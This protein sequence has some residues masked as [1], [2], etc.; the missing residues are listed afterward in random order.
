MKLENIENNNLQLLLPL[1]SDNIDVLCDS[2]TISSSTKAYV[3]C[4]ESCKPSECCAI[5]SEVDGSCMIGDENRRICALYNKPCSIIYNYDINNETNTTNTTTIV[6]DDNNEDGTTTISTATTDDMDLENICS[7]EHL[8]TDFGRSRCYDA[9]KPA[10]CCFDDNTLS[11]CLNKETKIWCDMFSPCTKIEF[12][13]SK[14]RKQ[15]QQQKVQYSDLFVE[16]SPSPPKEVCTD[17]Y[18][19]QY[20]YDE[21]KNS[22]KNGHC[23]FIKNN[24]NNSTTISEEEDEC[25]TEDIN[26]LIYESCSIIYEMTN[27][28]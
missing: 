27:F 15:H 2:E 14:Y 19:L 8:S 26:C 9:C 22:C 24:N 23:C 4:Q 12:S 11:T 20:G 25:N 7:D 10:L 13:F 21:C 1:P 18:T 16:A 3:A 6:D 28:T 17:S 5:N